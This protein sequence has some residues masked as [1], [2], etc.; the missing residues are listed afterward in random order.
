[1]GHGTEADS[2]RV[3]PRMQETLKAAGYENYFIGTV[4]AEPA[5]DAL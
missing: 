1:M 4:E 5:L 2:N 3:Y